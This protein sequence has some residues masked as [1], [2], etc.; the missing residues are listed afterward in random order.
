MPG[1]NENEDI[2][3]RLTRLLLA[4]LLH[5]GCDSVGVT[6]SYPKRITTDRMR[7]RC[8]TLVWT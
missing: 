1:A 8:I 7:D 5:L 6:G 4:E 2:S 3:V